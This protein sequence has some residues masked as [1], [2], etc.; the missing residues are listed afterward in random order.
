ML[1]IFHSLTN[2]TLP[3][4]LN[5]RNQVDNE[6]VVAFSF[7]GQRINNISPWRHQN[8]QERL[9]RLVKLANKKPSLL[10]SDQAY[11]QKAQKQRQVLLQTVFSSHPK[12]QIQN[13]WPDIRRCDP[14]SNYH[15]KK[16]TNET[17]WDLSTDRWEWSVF[18]S[19]TNSLGWGLQRC[20]IG[21]GRS[22]DPIRKAAASLRNSIPFV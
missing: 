12:L 9:M 4:R 20:W 10:E 7:A 22:R 18:V 3:S 14:L 15:A 5:K 6:T 2:L 19:F 13:T 21:G 16:G 11:W 1:F 8:S 17:S